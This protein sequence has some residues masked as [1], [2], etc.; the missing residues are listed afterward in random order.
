MTTL[1][2]PN[3]IKLFDYCETEKAFYIFMELADEDLLTELLE[4]KFFTES[5]TK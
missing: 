2:H 1:S 4:N 5:E 3:I